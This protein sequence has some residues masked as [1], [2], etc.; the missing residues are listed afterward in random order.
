[1]KAN[2]SEGA[3]MEWEDAFEEDKDENSYLNFGRENSDYLAKKVKK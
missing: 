3:E 1:M 2:A